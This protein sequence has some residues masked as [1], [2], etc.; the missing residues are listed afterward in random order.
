MISDDIRANTNIRGALRLQD[1]ADAIDVVG[2]P[3]PTT[4]P[5]RLAGRAVLRLGPDEHVTFQA[6]GCTAVSAGPG[7]ANDLT[8]IVRAVCDAHRLAGGERPTAPWCPPLPR[9]LT[10]ADV[11]ARTGDAAIAGVLGLLDD[12]DQQDQRALRWTADGHVLVGG[13][14]GSGVTS[15]LVAAGS[16]ALD[17]DEATHLYVVDGR[18]DGALAALG[19]HPRC[20]AVVL[21]HEGE[22]LRRLLL[23]L[24][25]EIDRR[26]AGAAAGPPIVLLVDGFTRLRMELG[27][28]DTQAELAALDH[29][30][31]NGAACGI[32]AVLAVEQ[33]SAVP[34]SVLARCPHRWLA[35]VVDGHEAIAWGFTARDVPPAIPGRMAVGAGLQAQ[36]VHATPRPRLSLA[37]ATDVAPPV[38]ELPAA[39]DAG[40]LG[41]AGRDAAGTLA[42]PVGLTFDDTTPITL[43]VP[44]G[45]HVVIVGPARSGRTTA[46]HRI[47]AAWREVHPVGWVG[48]LAPRRGGERTHPGLAELLADVPSDGPVLIAVDDAELVPDEPGP[49]SLAALAGVAPARTARGHGGQAG[50]AAPGVRPL[51]GHAA[52]QPA[53]AGAR[54]QWRPRRR[55]ARR[56][57]SPSPP[58]RRPPRPRL[59]RRRR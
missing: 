45:D 20:A 35:H 46:L 53:R 58:D 59:A 5:R 34:P 15:A 9:E 23:R 57:P 3:T 30:V 47:V 54:G 50:C 56:R 11:A 55:P 12:P 26:A 19:G 7:G 33:P 16:A 10:A 43:D 28:P 4:I 37:V 41:R 52:P 42:L 17:V 6:A 38:E 2:V 8:T 22:R 32:T 13:G 21:G 1:A 18:G 25:G 29:I 44:D 24:S 48:V 14:H 39:V 31:A 51:D 40:C 27:E 36:L 49:V